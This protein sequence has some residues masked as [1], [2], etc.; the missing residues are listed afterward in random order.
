[1]KKHGLEN[2]K[3][4]DAMPVGMSHLEMRQDPITKLWIPSYAPVKIPYTRESRDEVRAAAAKWVS[5]NP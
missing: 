4:G 3:Q 5:E 1:L 2:Y